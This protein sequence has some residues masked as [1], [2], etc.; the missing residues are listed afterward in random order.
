MLVKSNVMFTWLTFCPL[1]SAC[2]IWHLSPVTGHPRPCPTPSAL[3]LA[4]TR[5]VVDCSPGFT[6]WPLVTTP[7]DQ[8][9]G[10][11]D[12]DVVNV[13]VAFAD[14][15]S[16]ELRHLLI[17]GAV[18]APVVGLHHSCAAA[19]FT[20]RSDAA[21]NVSHGPTR[22]GITPRALHD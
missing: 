14:E 8:S 1:P 3:G 5:T 22:G 18:G 6:S 12:Q 16:L 2:C 13:V 20:D 9:S 11:L 21:C 7:S 10:E 15:G 4:R 17:E 19:S